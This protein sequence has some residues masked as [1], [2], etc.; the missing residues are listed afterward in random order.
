M[1]NSISVNQSVSSV[2][3]GVRTS[4]S[5]NTN[6]YTTSSNFSAGSQDVTSSAATVISFSQLSDV[7]TLTV[8]NDNTV[9][10]ASV[11]QI[12]GSTTAPINAI[13][14]PGEQ[15]TIPWS[16]SMPNISGKVVGS[17]PPFGAVVQNGKGT[18]QFLAQQS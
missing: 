6:A 18:I 17:Y 1:P 10:S 8:V 13:L 4:I 16:G 11:I 14:K 12:T 3:D 5:S 7:F 9:Y 2:I 15:T